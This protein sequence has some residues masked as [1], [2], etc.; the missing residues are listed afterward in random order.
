MRNYN[1][2]GCVYKLSGNRRKPWAVR[3]TTGWK[4]QGD[5]AIQQ[6]QYIGYYETRQEAIHALSD[7]NDD[8]Y[9]LH[10]N[11]IT[12]EEVYEKWSAR[13]YEEISA[14]NVKGYK[15]AW[16]L[17]KPIKDMKFTTLKL[18]HLQ[19]VVDE[20]GKHTPT[21]K[22]VKSLFKSL[23]EYAVI[24]G[25]IP[26]E[27]N[28]VRYLD[29]SQGGNPDARQ[30]I[31]FTKAEISHL[32]EVHEQ[33][34]YYDIVLMLIYSGVRI[35]ELLNLKK[36]DVH[37]S[38]RW[39]FVRRSKTDAGIRSV[40]IAKK[41]MPFFTYWMQKNDCDY[42]IST[43]DAKHMTYRNF[44]DSYWK[45]LMKTLDMEKHKPHDTRHTCI[46]M[47]TAEKIDERFIQ[48]IVGHKGQN[49]T[50][51][52]YTHLEIEELIQEIDKI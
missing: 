3:K 16:K 11:T 5:K 9:D 36:E 8:P 7:Y 33:S 25:I 37:L 38:E 28:V 22:K 39:F 48:K 10:L 40:P 27:K 41:V 47:M 46:S 24:H 30:H 23:F 52:V 18:D 43:T 35:S 13:K 34:E 49:V 42:L 31:P 20:S 32:W 44:M 17:C 6:Y 45:P 2:Y 51:Q 15:A 12:L 19:K 1:G 26:P 29:I 21:L 4:I 50:Q 14:S